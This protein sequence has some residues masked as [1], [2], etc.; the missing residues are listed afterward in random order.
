MDDARRK[1]SIKKYLYI[2]ESGIKNTIY[3][4]NTPMK[5]DFHKYIILIKYH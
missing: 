5:E 1:N 4:L 3:R 2:V